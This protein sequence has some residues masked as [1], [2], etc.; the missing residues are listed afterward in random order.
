MQ[1]M[2]ALVEL[3]LPQALKQK[4]LNY[5]LIKLSWPALTL[6]RESLAVA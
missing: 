3:K 2:P 1:Y 4:K 5:K 6:S